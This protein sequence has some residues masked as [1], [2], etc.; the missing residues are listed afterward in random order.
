MAMNQLR[1]LMFLRRLLMAIVRLT[2]LVE[3][4]HTE[5]PEHVRRMFEVRWQVNGVPSYFAA[6]D[7]GMLM[8]NG[9]WGC[10]PL[11]PSGLCSAHA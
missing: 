8:T 1:L 4:D 3:K 10:V 6:P 9:F 2:S 7:N 11:F 5:D